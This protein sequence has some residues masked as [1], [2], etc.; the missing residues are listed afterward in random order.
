MSRDR[1]TIIVDAA[2]HQQS[3][4]AAK[5]GQGERGRFGSRRQGNFVKQSVAIRIKKFNVSSSVVSQGFKASSPEH[6]RIY[7]GDSS[8][9]LARCSCQTAQAARHRQ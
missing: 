6:R 4:K 3:A 2:I 5:D 1:Q 8:A 9:S 7:F